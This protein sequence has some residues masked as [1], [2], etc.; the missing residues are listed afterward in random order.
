MAKR[1]GI[2][3]RMLNLRKRPAKVRGGVSAPS[4]FGIDVNSLYILSLLL[5]LN[6][7]RVRIRC[8]D[9]RRCVLSCLTQ[10][11]IITMRRFTFR[12]FVPFSARDS[13]FD[14]A[15]SILPFQNTSTK[16]NGMSWKCF[17]LSSACLGNI[18]AL[19]LV[20]F[21]LLHRYGSL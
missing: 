21:C 17:N 16:I 13:S 20:L 1:L 7:F 3:C 8:L 18:Q 5:S 10:I 19:G 2:V 11:W 4:I 6:A 14:I 9:S 15:R 12:V